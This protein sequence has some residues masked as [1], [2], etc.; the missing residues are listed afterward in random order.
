MCGDCITYIEVND[1]WKTKFISENS[2]L[3]NF[4]KVYISICNFDTAM[5][6]INAKQMNQ[7]LYDFHLENNMDILDESLE[8]KDDKVW[9]IKNK[10]LQYC[11]HKYKMNP[12][13]IEIATIGNIVPNFCNNDIYES[14]MAREYP[15]DI[16]Y[17]QKNNGKFIHISY[18]GTMV[19]ALTS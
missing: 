3:T 4:E 2:S 9:T 14:A 1:Y 10:W 5:Y 19:T 15:N 16:H 7:L 18:N 17:K 8:A 13:S 12:N 6:N 11:Y